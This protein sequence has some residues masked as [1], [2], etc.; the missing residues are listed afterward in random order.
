MPFWVDEDRTPFGKGPSPRVDPRRGAG[1]TPAKDIDDRIEIFEGV[2]IAKGCAQ[3]QAGQSSKPYRG[4]HRIHTSR[5]RR[6]SK[7]MGGENFRR[8]EAWRHHPLLRARWY[9]ALPGFATGAA[10]FAVYLA[11]ETYTSTSDDK[12]KAH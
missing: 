4:R 7:A 11:Y 2:S 9:H 1:G 10:A 3:A 5:S 8:N 6:V 12:R